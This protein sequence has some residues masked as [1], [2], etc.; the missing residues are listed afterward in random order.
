LYVINSSPTACP[1]EIHLQPQ[2]QAVAELG[3]FV[4]RN[5]VPSRRQVQHD[6]RVVFL[7]G[8]SRGVGRDAAIAL[9]GQGWDLALVA[10][11]ETELKATADLCTAKG[12]RI[13]TYA[14][15]VANIEALENAVHDCVESLGNINILINNAGVNRRRSSLVSSRD[16]WTQTMDINLSACMHATRVALPYMQQNKGGAILYISSIGMARLTGTARE[17]THSLSLS[18]THR[19]VALVNLVCSCGTTWCRWLCYVLRIEMGL[20]WFCSMRTRG[21]A[22]SGHQGQLHL[23]WFDQ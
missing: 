23:P 7:T 13:K 15:D 3:L 11:S 8:A 21:C 4:Y 20:A 16:V 1:A 10:R 19:L 6:R 22:P 18:L 5:E 2:Q 12:V 14:L 17:C 9:A